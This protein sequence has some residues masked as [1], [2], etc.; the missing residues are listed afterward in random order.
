[1]AALIGNDIIARSR[2]SDHDLVLVRKVL[3][4]LSPEVLGHPLSRSFHRQLFNEL[5]AQICASRANEVPDASMPAGGL[6]NHFSLGPPKCFNDLSAQLGQVWAPETAANGPGV[7]TET[8]PFHLSFG[9]KL[10][11]RDTL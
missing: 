11:R 2:S 3:P 6:R 9:P 5:Q 4:G 7:L 10:S 8:G 1:M